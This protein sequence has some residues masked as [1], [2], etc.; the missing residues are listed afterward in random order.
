MVLL[1]KEYRTLV[2]AA[3]TMLIFSKTLKFLWAEAIAT[4]C[5]T[6]NCSLVHIRYNKTPY[7]LIKGRKPN[8]QYFHVFGFLCYP[9]NDHDDLGKMKPKAD[10][11]IFIGYSESSRGFCIYNHQTKKIMETIHVT[12]DEL[13]TMA[14]ECN[15]SGPKYYAT[16]TPK[17]SAN[18]VVNTLD[19]EDT[20]SSFLIVVKENEAHQVVTSSNEPVVNEPTTPVSN[21]NANKLV[22]E[23]VA[24]FDKN[25]FYNPFHS[26]MLEETE[27]SS[28]FE[29]PSNMHEF[30]QTHRSN[31]KWSKNHPIEQV[32]VDPSKPVM[33]RHR[34]HTDAKMCM[35]ALTFKRLD[36]WELVERP[37]GRNI[38]AVKWLW[39]NKTDAENTV[40]LNKS[41]LVAQG[42]GQEE[43]ID[44]EESFAPV[45]RI[46]A[47]RIFIA[48]TAHKTFLFTRWMSR[49]HS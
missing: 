44:F 10:I 19:N 26:L 23:D 34:L 21:E 38:I 5:F 30:Y 35:Y 11:G 9:I 3:R 24:A 12:F 20:P 18:S 49:W 27:S 31:D 7:E 39:K 33:T 32:I 2:K 46:E 29:D 37:V 45:A 8:V 43:G 6:Q 1:N 25:D 47:V 48:Y 36:V 16:S 13:A 41:R 14:S 28:A 17:V 22:Q 40:I 42:Y 4:A 15:N